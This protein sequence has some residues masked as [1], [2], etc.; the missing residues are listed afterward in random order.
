MSRPE[1]FC[2]RVRFTHEDGTP[3]H[4]VR[5]RDRDTGRLTFRVTSGGAQGNTK[6]RTSFVEYE[7]ELVKLLRAGSSVRCAPLH[8][9]TQNIYSTKSR[10]IVRTDWID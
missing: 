7:S 2:L 10:S 4:P 1:R 9:G 6:A 5:V 8:G 3:Y